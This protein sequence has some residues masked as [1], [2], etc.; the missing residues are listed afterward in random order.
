MG[1]RGDFGGY[2]Q[3]GKILER[4]EREKEKKYRRIGKLGN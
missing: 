1:N 2:E 3:R 4:H